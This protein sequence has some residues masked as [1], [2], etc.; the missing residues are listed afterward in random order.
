[1]STDA[2]V[3]EALAHVR[4]Q[5]DAIWTEIAPRV[6]GLRMEARAHSAKDDRPNPYVA[7]RCGAGTYKDH[8]GSWG[9]KD[10]GLCPRCR[11]AKDHATRADELLREA[12]RVY[13][14]AMALVDEDHLDAA[15]AAVVAAVGERY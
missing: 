14:S 2:R 9:Q 7:C 15:L 3:R 1:M 5:Q 8:H 10:A 12:H 4:K 6:E 11:T 13:T